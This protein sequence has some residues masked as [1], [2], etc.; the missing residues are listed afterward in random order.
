MNPLITLAAG[1]PILLVCGLLA[2]RVRTTVAALISI[3]AAT[4]A[5]NA[6]LEAAGGKALDAEVPLRAL[7]EHGVDNV[8]R[9][10]GEDIDLGSGEL[11]LT[12]TRS[13][14]LISPHDD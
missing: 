14:A 6:G 13:L 3:A 1:A 4:T 7:F 12:L 2:A 5:V 11:G 10:V 9:G 8:G